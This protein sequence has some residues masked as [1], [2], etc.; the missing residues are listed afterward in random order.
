MGKSFILKFK[1]KLYGKIQNQISQDT[2]QVNWR[3]NVIYETQ[4]C[5]HLLTGFSNK[6]LMKYTTGIMDY[7]GFGIL[8]TR[9]KIFMMVLTML[10]R[11]GIFYF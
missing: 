2:V 5:L 9:I 4:Q 6:I 10:P 11:C 3:S 1:I 7:S 8:H